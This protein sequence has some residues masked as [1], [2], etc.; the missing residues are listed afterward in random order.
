MRRGEQ[1][2]ARDACGTPGGDRGVGSWTHS[3]GFCGQTGL[4]ARNGTSS[5]E[6]RWHRSGAWAWGGGWQRGEGRGAGRGR[7]CP[8]V[9]WQ[10]PAAP[11]KLKWS[12]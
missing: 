7:R 9:T 11:K 10:L 12:F 8:P 6:I 4:E 5:V 1:I 3:S 2:W